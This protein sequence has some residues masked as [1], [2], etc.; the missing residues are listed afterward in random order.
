MGSSIDAWNPRSSHD[1]GA[2]THSHHGAGR[3]LDWDDLRSFLAIARHGTLSAAA[4]ALGVRQTTMGRRLAA[5]QDRAGA[6]L[7]MKTPGGFVLTQAGETILP[8]VERIEAEALAVERRVSGRDIRLEGVVRISTIEILAVEV[9]TPAFAR[10]REEHPGITLEV[11]SEVRNVSL[12][13]READIALGLARLT[14][15]DLV[16]RRV[17]TIGFGVYAAPAYLERFGLPDFAAGAPGH[18]T[19]PNPADAMGLP[20]MAW[21]S[22]LTHQAR[23]GI[24]HNSRYGQRAAAIAGMG[25]AVLSRL[26]SEG[27]TLIPLE[28]PIPPPARDVFLAVHDDIRHTPRIRAV[29]DAIAATMRAQGER[30]APG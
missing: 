10:L 13:R 16:V 7:L 27:T 15:G 9:L 29:T 3:M 1:Q 28:T 4:R 24:R 18:V 21:F 2:K 26:M 19:I 5:L 8:H 22:A 14:Q 12:T 20:E 11:S 17:G 23:P 30:L 25:L 6:R